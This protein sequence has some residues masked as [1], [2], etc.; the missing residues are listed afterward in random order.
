MLNTRRL[1]V[2]SCIAL[3]TSAFTFSL[4]G[5]VMQE[6]GKAFNFTQEQNGSIAKAIFW[7]MAA[8]M[9]VGGFVCDFLG[10]KRVMFLALASHLTGVT[11][12]VF[13]RQFLPPGSTTDAYHHW[14]WASAFIM[15]CG[16]GWTEVGINPLVATLYP[17]AK[18]K[19]LNIL[20]A[21]WPG[22][23]VIGGL[24]AHFLM[25][26]RSMANGTPTSRW[27]MPSAR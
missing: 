3:V 17:H 18:T 5:D 8:S 11:G 12:L 27:P 24:L 13:A 2:C 25:R 15:G 10:V 6:I 9:L 23:L 1:F 4:H 14:M 22:G 20:H 16:N 7:G 19:F 21:W 26:A